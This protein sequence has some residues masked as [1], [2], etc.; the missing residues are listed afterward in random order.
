MYQI[1]L[2][3]VYQLL[4]VPQPPQY[5]YLAMLLETI[6][7]E[8][9]RNFH[10]RPGDGRRCLWLPLVLWFSGT[11][12]WTV[13]PQTNTAV[14]CTAGQQSFTPTMF[15]PVWMMFRTLNTSCRIFFKLETKAVISTCITTPTAHF[16]TLWPWPLISGSMHAEALPKGICVPIL[17]L[18]AQVVFLLKHG[19]INK[20]TITSHRCHALASAGMSNNAEEQQGQ[21]LHIFIENNSWPFAWQK[22]MQV[23]ISMLSTTSFIFNPRT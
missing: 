4:K 10:D 1:P 12:R 3:V 23:I 8:T 2:E 15:M 17:V 14:R 9:N 7:V 21:Q 11:G 13:L 6:T 20:R 18:I 16:I 5:R 19:H 22:A